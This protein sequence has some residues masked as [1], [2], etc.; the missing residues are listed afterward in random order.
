MST[1]IT[2]INKEDRSD[3]DLHISKVMMIDDNASKSDIP[4]KTG[5]SISKFIVP[6]NGY[7]LRFPDFSYIEF[8]DDIFQLERDV[9][10]N[11]AN[12][13]VLRIKAGFVWNGVTGINE[14]NDILER[15]VDTSGIV[16]ASLIHD[17]LSYIVE[18]EGRCVVDA[19]FLHAIEHYVPSLEHS[20]YEKIFQ[21][22]LDK[23]STLGSSYMFDI[24]DPDSVRFNRLI[25]NNFVHWSIQW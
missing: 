14:S 3:S 13:S 10:F 8:D 9:L 21:F 24:N 4:A 1:I 22:F 15:C 12:R 19:L 25:S 5:I 6:V 16:K 7:Q 18:D 17:V 2:P 23:A 11:L 20:I